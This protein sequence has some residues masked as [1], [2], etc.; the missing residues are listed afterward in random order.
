MALAP[1]HRAFGVR[2]VFAS[3]YQAVS[4]AGARAIEEL[5]DQTKRVSAGHAPEPEVFAH[6]IAFNVI[7][8]IDVFQENLY[9]KAEMKVRVC[10]LI[11]ICGCLFYSIIFI[12]TS[13]HQLD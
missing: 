1:L 8:H 3:S 4:G 2:R 6:Q 13:T 5:R 9:T 12:H 7:P 11:F 10:M